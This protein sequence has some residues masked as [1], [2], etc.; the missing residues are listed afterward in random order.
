MTTYSE[1]LDSKEEGKKLRR[2]KSDNM[3]YH[4]RHS[5]VRERSN[6]LINFSKGLQNQT[7]LEVPKVVKAIHSS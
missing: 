3:L 2:Q 6:S 4:S 5:L 7:K 1:G